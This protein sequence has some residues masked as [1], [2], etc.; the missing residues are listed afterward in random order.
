MGYEFV[1]KS[2]EGEAKANCYC[3]EGYVEW[4]DGYCYRLYTRGPCEENN[5]I[6]DSNKC[7]KNPCEKGR[8]YFPNEQTCYRIGSQGMGVTKLKFFNC[9]QKGATF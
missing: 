8:L 4:K 7:M 3:K 9:S 5:F 6:T 2:L 1:V